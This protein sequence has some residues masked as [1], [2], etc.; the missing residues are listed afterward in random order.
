MIWPFGKYEKRA[1]SSY[2]DAL[3]ASLLSNAGNQSSAIPYATG[4]LE[5]VA[6]LVGRAFAVADVSAPDHLTRVLDPAFWPCVDPTRRAR[7]L[8]PN[9]RTRRAGFAPL[10]VA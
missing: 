6:G 4:A 8:H 1:D 3:V 5:S 10:W 7:G 9:E 2:T